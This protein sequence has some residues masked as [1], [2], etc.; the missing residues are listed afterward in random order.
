M[1]ETF[2]PRTRGAVGAALVL[3]PLAVQLPF[4]WLAAHYDYPAILERPASEVLE[5]FAA[6]GAP[7]ILAWYTYALCT[8]GLGFVAVALPEALGQRG[9][10]GR[11]ITVTGVIASLV[12]LVGLLR[13]TMVVPFLAERWV[14]AP[15]ERP[16]LALAYE[17]QHRLFGVMLGEHVGQLAMGTFTFLIALALRARRGLA[18]A[19]RARRGL[20]FAG[21]VAGSLFVLGTSAQLARALPLPAFVHQGPL[22]AFVAWSVW[23]VATGVFL[24]RSAHPRRERQPEQH[25]LG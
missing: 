8:L 17:V 18:L 5:R 15:A 1:N 25:A 22:V 4:G 7:M 24:V 20:A 10:L 16:T 12:Q 6:G 14:Q 19:L 2:S 11:A 13:W 23:A 21:A 9:A 3:F